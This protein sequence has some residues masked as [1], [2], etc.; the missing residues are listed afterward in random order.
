[1][2]RGAT[3]R[4]FTFALTAGEVLL[5]RVLVFREFTLAGGTLAFVFLFAFTFAGRLLLV[6]LLPV[7]LLALPFAFSFV[8][9]GLG[10]LG[11]FSLAFE[12]GLRFAF[13]FSSA[14]MV[15]GDSPCF[16]GRLMSIATV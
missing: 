6:F 16:V 11:L 13:A 3:G 2:G 5:G 15:S 8:F 1:M 4:L 9:L 10:R 12:F 14:G 7:L